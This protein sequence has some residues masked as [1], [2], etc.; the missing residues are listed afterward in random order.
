M[1]QTLLLAFSLSTDAFAA[2]IAKGARFPN[3]SWPRRV[4]IA[5]GFGALEALAPLIGYIL[6]IQ[7]A[8]AIDDY[9]HWIAFG[10]LGAL[11]LRMIWKSFH[12]DGEDEQA[13]AAPSLAAVIV[14]AMG[15]SVD[16]T[17]VGV[18]LALFSNNIPLTL[19]AIGLVTF[20]MTLLGLRL[21]G[22]IGAR[23]GEWAEFFGGLGLIAIGANILVTHLG[24]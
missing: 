22:A 13:S 9:D 3:L 14:T 6:G 16:A 5:C 4:S 15:T 23:T 21:G 12:P 24:R 8:A 11:G 2:S 19:G 18:T 1:I 17:V 10:L 20:G 7:F